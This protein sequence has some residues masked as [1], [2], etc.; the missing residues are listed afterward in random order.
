MKKVKYLILSLAFF[1]LANLKVNAASNELYDLSINVKINTDASADI[2]E[3]W[4]MK[5][6]QGTEV[7]KPMENLGS[8]VISNFKVKDESGTMYTNIS[9]NVNASLIGKK[10]KSGINYTS[11]G[12]ELCWGMGSY[13]KHIY[14]ISYHVTNF[15]RNLEDSQMI[16]WKLVNDSMNP[17]PQK[18][19]ITLSADKNFEDTIDVWG[20]GYKGYAYVADGK[21]HMET[22]TD[23]DSSE[24][25]VL[26]AKFDL[27]T[28]NATA[29]ESG[30]FDDWNQKAKEGS[31]Q[32]DYSEKSSII[33]K[34]AIFM[35]TITSLIMPLIWIMIITVVIKAAN[36]NNMYDIEFGPEGKK[37]D[38]KSLNYFRDLPCKKDIFRAYFVATLYDLNK[39]KE[40]FLGTV[41]LKWLN[42]EKIVVV[43]TPPKLFSKSKYSIDL[44]QKEIKTFENQ[45]E[46]AL[47]EMLSKASKDGILE[48]KEFEKWCS[49]N[50]SKILNWFDNVLKEEK[51]K[52]VADGSLIETEKVTLKVFKTKKYHVQPSLKEE[53]I[54]L[55]GLKKFL[56]EFSDMKNKEAIEVHLWKEYLMFAQIFGIANKVAKQFKNLYPDLITDM[57]YDGII[58]VNNIAYS[59][60]TRAKSARNSARSRAQSYSSGGGGFSSGGGGGGSFGGGSGGGCR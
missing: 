45:L 60:V 38:T 37:I 23:L 9:W 52:L 30:S 41:L 2:T 39:K 34:I 19:K 42:E 16:Y 4:T 10:Y 17:A 31:F 55:A 36:K 48:S 59:G 12:L 53:A 26:L 1:F 13:G 51:Q 56:V 20:Y 44:K 15:V 57:S 11:T 24:Y 3:V 8:S 5:V 6:G 29:K 28:F 47:Y 22:E 40:D 43:E 14:T 18:V 25:M 49:N 46:K 21:I 54:Q 7:Y 33:E 32:H 27:N 58:V 35:M 50:Y